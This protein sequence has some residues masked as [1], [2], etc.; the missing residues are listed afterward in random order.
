MR[1]TAG[2]RLSRTREVLQ[3]GVVSPILMNLFMHYPF[4]SWMTR[5][6]THCPFARYADDAVVH[7]RTEAQARN[8]MQAIA[9][10]LAECGLTMHPEKSKI[11]YCKEFIRLIEQLF[12]I[13]SHCEDMTP[14]NRLLARQH[15]SRSVLEQ[16]EALLLKQ[17]HAVL[18]HSAFGKALHYLQGQ[19]PKLTRFIETGARPIL[20]NP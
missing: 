14:A 5:K 19:W 3:G 10:R 11:V 15:E 9:S 12:A 4:D 13:E 18:P 2:P 1:Q 7:C 16:I 20:H 17:L 6:Y 8:A